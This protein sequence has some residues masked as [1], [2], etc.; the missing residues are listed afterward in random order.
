MAQREW[1]C[2]LLPAPHP[3]PAHRIAFHQLPLHTSNWAGSLVT[4]PRARPAALPPP[5]GPQWAPRS[6]RQRKLQVCKPQR[7]WSPVIKAGGQRPAGVGRGGLIKVSTPGQA[8]ES[9]LNN[10]LYS[11]PS[12]MA[13][14]RIRAMTPMTMMGKKRSGSRDRICAATASASGNRQGGGGGESRKPQSGGFE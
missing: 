1:P 10:E 4:K 7:F 11:L 14:A 12:P 9:P 2:L 3:G 6:S 8:L 5:P 13:S